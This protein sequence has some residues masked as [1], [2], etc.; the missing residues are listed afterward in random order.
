MPTPPIN[1]PPSRSDL[2]AASR[3][4]VNKLVE[5]LLAWKTPGFLFNSNIT[6]DIRPSITVSAIAALALLKAERREAQFT[7]DALLQARVKEGPDM[8]AWTAQGGPYSHTIGTSWAV[9]SCLRVRATC[10]SDLA[11]AVKWL[12]DQRPQGH[13]GW[14]HVKELAPRAYETAYVLNALLEF[15][16]CA[17]L[18]NFGDAALLGSVDDAIDGGVD[19]L[20]AAVNPE[21]DESYLWGDEPQGGGI[22]LATTAISIHVLAKYAK[23]RRGRVKMGGLLSAFEF[24]CPHITAESLGR[25]QIPVMLNGKEFDLDL[26]PSFNCNAPNSYWNQ[27]FTPILGVTFLDYYPIAA[28]STRKALS[29]AVYGFVQ[30]VVSHTAKQKDGNFGVRGRTGSN[31]FVWSTAQ[32]IILLCRWL[33]ALGHY[34]ELLSGAAGVVTGIDGSPLPAPAGTLA[35]SS[36]PLSSPLKPDRLNSARFAAVLRQ[37]FDGITDIKMALS[38][39]DLDPATYIKDGE[40]VENTIFEVFERLDGNS[41]AVIEFLNVAEKKGKHVEAVKDL[42]RRFLKEKYASE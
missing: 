35:T 12:L 41:V 3:D 16:E 27:Y 1:D 14:G 31:A 42:R 22:C 33:D 8:G 24:L 38:D 39:A 17:L 28:P 23:I 32:G 26:W 36:V 21:A 18:A 34:P 25:A 20:L 13:G 15:R 6:G 4:T 7:C 9:F 29:C 19:F 5:A 11:E 40:T 30:W 2:I 10:L 37:V